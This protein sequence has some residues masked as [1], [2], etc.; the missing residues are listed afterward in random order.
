MSSTFGR[1]SRSLSPNRIRNSLVV[2]YMNGRPTTCLRPTIL[3][4]WRS[5]RVFSTPEV[6]DAADV[7]DLGPGDRLTVGNHGQRL[8]RLHRQLLRAALV[9]QPPHPFVEI[10]PGDDLIATGHLHQLQPARPLVVQFQLADRGQH[11]LFRLA[12]EQLEQP[13]RRERIGRRKDQR[14]D[15]RLEFGG[16]ST[17]LRNA[18]LRALGFDSGLQAL[19]F[20]LRGLRA[21]GFGSRL[22]TWGFGL[23]GLRAL[24]FGSELQA[25][26]F[27]LQGLWALGFGSGLQTWG[28]GLLGL[29]A[30]GFR[31]FDAL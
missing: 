13:L 22:Q 16:G 6:F 17:G 28:F 19:G 30:L 29:R 9:E 8:E 31:P 7:G 26:G 24:G 14:L 25:L 27:G 23:L 20:R 5:S 15:D 3:I 11:V 1:S 4:K 21:L 18:G 12:V 2:E 10:R